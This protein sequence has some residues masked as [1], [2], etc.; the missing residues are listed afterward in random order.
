VVSAPILPLL[1]D[2]TLLAATVYM[3]SGGEPFEGKLAVAWV[4]VNRDATGP[5]PGLDDVILR[6]WAFSA[7]NT[8]HRA[9]AALQ[10]AMNERPVAWVESMKAAAA[11]LFGLV[12]DPTNGATHY[13]N[14]ALTRTIRGGTLPDWFD[15]DKVTARLGQ[16]TFL[17]L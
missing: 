13:L 12:P 7:W 16:H 9:R 3:E 5:D 1:D 10:T 17:R 4:I 6:P 11:A 2:L 15:A 14:E 8:D